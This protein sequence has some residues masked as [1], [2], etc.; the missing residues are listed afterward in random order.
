MENLTKADEAANLTKAGE[1]AKKVGMSKSKLYRAAA[2]G[3]I[4]HYR[5]DGALRFDVEELRQWMK[6]GA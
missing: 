6:R 1:A 5:F 3:K 2:A 4:P